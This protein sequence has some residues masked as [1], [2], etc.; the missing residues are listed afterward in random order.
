MWL[1]IIKSENEANFS[2]SLWSQIVLK[3]NKFLNLLVSSL[4][5]YRFWQSPIYIW[6]IAHTVLF[7]KL[8]QD[9]WILAKETQSEDFLGLCYP[10]SFPFKSFSHLRVTCFWGSVYIGFPLL[11]W[12]VLCKQWRM[13]RPNTAHYWYR[14]ANEDWSKN[15][16]FTD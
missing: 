8:I 11:L 10:S 13:E 6:D 5:R 1:F 2:Y 14:E 12:V 4:R 15:S 7:I 3:D 9:S 16:L